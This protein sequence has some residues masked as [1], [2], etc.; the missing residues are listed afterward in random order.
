MD[1]MLTV[2]A[3]CV[4]SFSLCVVSGQLN[5]LYLCFD[6][7][8]LCNQCGVLQPPCSGLFFSVRDFINAVYIEFFFFNIVKE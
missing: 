3:V 4:A 1:L 6:C 2:V 5:V 7:S 8:L